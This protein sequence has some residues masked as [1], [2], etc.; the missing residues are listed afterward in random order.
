VAGSGFVAVAWFA[1]QNVLVVI[2]FTEELLGKEKENEA[3]S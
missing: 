1:L 3:I 2:L